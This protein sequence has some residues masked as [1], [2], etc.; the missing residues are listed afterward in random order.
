MILL[1]G[2]SGFIGQQLLKR[3]VSLYGPENVIALTSQPIEICKYVLHSNYRFSKEIFISNGFHEISTIIHAGAF[4]PKSGSDANNIEKCISNIS[5]TAKLLNAELPSL[6]KVIFLSTID[7]YGAD[8]PIHEQ[9]PVSPISLYGYSKLFCEQLIEKWA[10]QHSKIC[11]VLRV[12]HVYGPGEEEYKKLI[13]E[14]MRRLINGKNITLY[15][16]GHEIRSFIFIS[17]IIDAIIS[18]LNKNKY[19]GPVNLVGEEQISVRA[20]IKKLVMI[21]KKS[22]GV[23]QKEALSEPRDLIFCNTKLK[24]ELTIPKMSLDEGLKTE[25]DYMQSIYS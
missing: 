17:D 15:G 13:P 16:E 23:E 6:N 19:L 11:Q 24:K 4:T 3:L 2:A 14:L 12:G 5:N 18:S 7:V 22:V 20:L 10:D 9:S 8:N 21:S 25:W 1:T